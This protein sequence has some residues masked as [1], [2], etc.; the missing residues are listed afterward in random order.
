MKKIIVIALMLALA[1]PVYAEEKK[2]E[3]APAAVAKPAAEVKKNADEKSNSPERKNENPG[4]L[5]INIESLQKDMPLDISYGSRKAPVKIVEYASLSCSHCRH[6]HE[7]VFSELEKTYIRDGKVRF[8]FRH[9]P[10]N[11]QAFKASMLVQCAAEERRALFLSALFKSQDDWGSQKDE[12]SLVEKLKSVAEVGG[13]SKDQF[14][15]CLANE[16]QEKTISE[17]QVVAANDLGIDS[18][19]TIFINGEKF[20][21]GKSFSNIADAIEQILDAKQ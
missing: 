14:D 9:F 15:K 12:K 21:G 13:L 7:Q 11:L 8:V 2:A 16:K 3:S 10:L 4:G 20:A 5:V 1:I 19:P 17:N 18:T 6:F